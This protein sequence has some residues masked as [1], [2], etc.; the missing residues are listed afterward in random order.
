MALSEVTAEDIAKAEDAIQESLEVLRKLR[1]Y[2]KE[3]EVEKIAVNFGTLQFHITEL[4][5]FADAVDARGKK[6]IL[7][8]KAK[9]EQAKRRNAK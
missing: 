5:I 8:Q 6:D 1:L 7:M 9:R 3:R 2:M 4:R